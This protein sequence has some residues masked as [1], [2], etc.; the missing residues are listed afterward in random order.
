MNEDTSV[1]GV[2]ARELTDRIYVYYGSGTGVLF[3]IPSY[4]RRAVEAI[5][6]IVLEE[7]G[8]DK[9]EE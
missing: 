1:L 6:K 9:E 3:G 2:Y 8:H 7:I 4:C 5:V